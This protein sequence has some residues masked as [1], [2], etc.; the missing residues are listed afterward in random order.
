MSV[1]SHCGLQQADTLR[2]HGLQLLA[3]EKGSVLPIDFPPIDPIN[4]PDFESVIQTIG[5]IA[6]GE[7][8]ALGVVEHYMLKLEADATNSGKGQ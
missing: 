2:L 4:L 8:S 1:P 3:L 6:V 7:F 5:A